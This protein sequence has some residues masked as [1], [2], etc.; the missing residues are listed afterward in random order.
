M[1]QQTGKERRGTPR[2]STEGRL[3]GELPLDLESDVR[4][5]SVGGM[6]IE[7]G[8]RL[9]IGSRQ[10]FTLTLGD[11]SME[12]DGV[13]RNCQAVSDEPA[14]GRFQIGVAF[15][16]LEPGQAESLER[17]VSGKLRG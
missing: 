17:F 3:S 7:V 9:E 16:D 8:V 12:V 13:V 5:L 11:S 2:V 10:R 1:S 4:Q 15:V 14:N 6:M